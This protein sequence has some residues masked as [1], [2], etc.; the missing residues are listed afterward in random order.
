MDSKKLAN[1][2]IEKLIQDGIHNNPNEVITNLTDNILSHYEIE[3]LK[4]G[5]KHAVAIIPKG[6]EMIVIMEDIYDQIMRHNVVKDN[7]IST[8]QLKTTL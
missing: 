1:L 5:L 7:Y 6:S 8:K 4:Y 2:I 3:I